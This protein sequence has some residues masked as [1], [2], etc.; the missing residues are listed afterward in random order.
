MTQAIASNIMNNLGELPVNSAV[1]D[2]VSADFE[3]IFDKTMTLGDIKNVLLEGAS[4]LTD[5]KEILNHVSNEVNVENSLDLTLARDINEIITQLKNAVTDSELNEEITDIAEDKGSDDDKAEPVFEQLLVVMD[6]SRAA[7]FSVNNTKVQEDVV[8]EVEIPE[9]PEVKLPEKSENK[10]NNNSESE[11][12]LDEEMLKE[13]NIESV[14]AETDTSDDGASLMQKQSPQ[15]QAV[16]VMLNH[17]TETFDTKIQQAS[18]A[19]Q[20][21]PVEV[22]STN[23]MEQISKQM[24]ALQNNSRVS[25]VLNPESMGK[26]TIQLVKSPEG[27]SAQF[28]TTTQEARD[29]L[30]KGMDGLKET[31]TAHG[32]GVDNV[33]VKVSDSQKS[34]YNSDW[35]EQEGSR[36]GNKEQGGQRKEEKERGLFEKMMAQENEKK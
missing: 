20:A 24:E 21:K 30:M 29:L 12:S 32:V 19:V 18:P 26:V 33:S 4:E 2:N 27:L 10:D 25:I 7:D 36:G 16:K 13:L 28:T 31:L 23:I 1:T 14:K 5:F 35:T 8:Q 11:L 6:T 34:E 17:S 3:A 9:Q 22:T 15:E